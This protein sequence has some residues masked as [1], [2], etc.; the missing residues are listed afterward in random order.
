MSR[1]MTGNTARSL[2]ATSASIRTGCSSF[3]LGDAARL[4]GDAE[5][6][7]QQAR[8]SVE[9]DEPLRRLVVDKFANSELSLASGELRTY[10]NFSV[11]VM[12]MH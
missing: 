5:Y 2:S 11:W 3:E 12:E 8:Q 4:S 10:I 1:Y 7:R 9:R 6:R